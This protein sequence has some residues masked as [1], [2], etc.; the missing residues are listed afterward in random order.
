M[1]NVQ[2]LNI[3]KEIIKEK[4]E[5]IIKNSFYL[6]K[7][8]ND[9]ELINNIK[10]LL[11]KKAPLLQC[12]EYDELN[13]EMYKHKNRYFKEYAYQYS[14]ELL[15]NVVFYIRNNSLTDEEQIKNETEEIRKY[16]KEINK[17]SNGPLFLNSLNMIKVD[18]EKAKKIANDTKEKKYLIKK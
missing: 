12:S 11:L 3:E 18:K 6:Y 9:N 2:K 1:T 4:C 10:N 13:K 15:F 17:Y 8:M 16:V 14:L 7:H 5:F